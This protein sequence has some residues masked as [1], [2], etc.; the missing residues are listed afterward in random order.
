MGFIMKKLLSYALVIVMIVTGSILFYSCKEEPEI[1]TNVLKK[2]NADNAGYID[3]IV[4]KSYGIEELRSFFGTVFRNDR[5][6]YGRS[7]NDR[8]LTTDDVNAEFPIECMRRKGYCV[9]KVA[10]GGYYYV[11]RDTSGDNLSSVSSTDT[12]GKADTYFAVYLNSDSALSEDDFA[13]VKEGVST[14]ED[15]QRIDHSFELSFLTSGG[16]VSY[17]LMKDGSALEISY[18]CSDPLTAY[19]DMTVVSKKTITREDNVHSVLLKILEKDLPFNVND[20]YK[21]TEFVKGFVSDNAGYIDDI[22]TK[23]YGIEELRSFFGTV[24]DNDPMYEHSDSKGTITISDVNN[25]FPIEC[26]REKYAVYK[27][28]EGG[29]YYVFWS[30]FCDDTSIENASYGDVNNACIHF[31]VYLDPDSALSENDFASVKEGVSTAED[32]QRIDPSFEMNILMSSRLPSYSLLGDGSVMEI[33]YDPH[34]SCRSYAD[35][36][37]VSKRVITRREESASLLSLILKKDLPY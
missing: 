31:A 18:K 10:E 20:T 5:V 8:S 28:T 1:N 21:R 34:S 35:M 26:L 24:F 19:S 33:C 6:M 37:V 16:V 7:G 27:V 13:S 9:Y 23:S 4:T 32:V 17:S 14:A 15:V 36:T 11:F 25:R 3:D 30:L 2:Y 29:Y 12:A 22:V